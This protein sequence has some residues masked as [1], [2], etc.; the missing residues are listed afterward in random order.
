MDDEQSFFI[1]AREAWESLEK[2][3]QVEITTSSRG[4]FYFRTYTPFY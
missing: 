3:Y 4:L 2:M 1:S